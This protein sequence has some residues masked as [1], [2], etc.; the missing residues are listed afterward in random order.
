MDIDKGIGM[1]GRIPL[2]RIVR[3]VGIAFT[4]LVVALVLYLSF[5]PKESY[6]RISWIPFADKGDH[7]AAY[8]AFGFFFFLATLRI[9][10]SGKQRKIQARPHSTLHLTSWAGPSIIYTL[11]AGTLLGFVVEML[12]P[13]FGRSR[14]W[15]D[16]A[17]DF[18]GL[19]VG[20]AVVLLLLKGVGSYFTARPWLYDPNWKD[21]VDETR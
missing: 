20:L 12:Q 13:K 4:L 9:P 10:G 5:I 18:M 19:V 7:M 11:V 2:Q 16:L 6:P 3:S 15:M 8:A 14:E 21:E 1:R 17:A